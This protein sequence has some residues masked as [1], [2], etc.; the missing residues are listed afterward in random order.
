MQIRFLEDLH[1]HSVDLKQRVVKVDYGKG[2]LLVSYVDPVGMLRKI[3][4]NTV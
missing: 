3:Q 1:F 2:E 4:D